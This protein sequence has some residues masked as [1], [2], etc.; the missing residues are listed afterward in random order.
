MIGIL[1]K[2]IYPLPPEGLKKDKLI[3][4]VEL[5]YSYEKKEGN[6]LTNLRLKLEEHG[7]KFV[8]KSPKEIWEHIRT[9]NKNE[10]SVFVILIITYLNLYKSNYS[11][12]NEVRNSPTS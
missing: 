2:K 8:E 3:K 5:P 7:V 12:F 11:N 4:F 1:P 10:V 6:L 9:N